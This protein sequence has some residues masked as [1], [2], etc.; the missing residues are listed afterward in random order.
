MVHLAL[1]LYNSIVATLENVVPYDT[2]WLTLMSLH[3][4][5]L[6]NTDEFEQP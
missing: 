2:K 5:L 1:P 4:I 3:R 6:C